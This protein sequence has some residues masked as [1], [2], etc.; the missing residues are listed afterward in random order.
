M[1]A[2]F[3][4]KMMGGRVFFNNVEKYTVRGGGQPFVKVLVWI[5]NIV[6]HTVI[7]YNVLT[8]SKQVNSIFQW[9]YL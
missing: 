9:G 3:K 8:L 1:I 2:T 4:F 6:S 5:A 7:V